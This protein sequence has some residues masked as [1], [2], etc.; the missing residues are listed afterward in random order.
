MITQNAARDEIFTLF[1]NAWDLSIAIA[2]YVPEIDY[3]GMQPLAPPDVSKHWCRVSIQTV[4]E[5][6]ASLA[7]DGGMPGTRTYTTF[8]LIFIQIFSPRSA[9]NAFE[10]GILL[11]QIAKAAFRGKTTPGKIWFRNVRLNE[12]APENS[13][14]RLNV[15]AEFEYDEQG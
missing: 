13:F 8:G 1:K 4:G 6:Q 11:G 10:E 14:Y 12:L 7:N 2:G 5:H 9:S 15:V 3:Q